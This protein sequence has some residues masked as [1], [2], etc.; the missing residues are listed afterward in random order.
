M[1]ILKKKPLISKFKKLRSSSQ[2]L[3]AAKFIKKSIQKA[4]KEIKIFT[5][6][7]NDKKIDWSDDRSK[8]WIDILGSLR[9]GSENISI[10]IFLKNRSNQDENTLRQLLAFDIQ[11]FEI[12]DEKF[13]LNSNDCLIVIDPFTEQRQCMK[14]SSSLTDQII[15]DHTYVYHSDDDKIIDQIRK[16]IEKISSYSKKI[17]HDD[18][19]SL[20][21]TDIDTVIPNNKKSLN[22]AI[23][24][25]N[26]F[27]SSTKKTIKIIDPYLQNDRFTT[28]ENLG[29]YLRYLTRLLKKGITIQI[30]STG[31]DKSNLISLKTFFKPL[32]YEIEI[33]SYDLTGFHKNRRIIHDRYVIVDDKQLV[34]LGKGL[35][36]FF[37][38]EMKGFLNNS[39]SNTYNSN[40]RNV[41]KVLKDSFDYYWDYEKC[42]D[43][44]I[45][46]WPKTD[47][48][49]LK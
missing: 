35:T 9:I 17:N 21:N 5:S 8:G 46:N 48:R 33:I 32:G 24:K 20:D 1:R 38:S 19:V 2:S 29:F 7:I 16:N 36:I 4:T 25:L 31:H 12:D 45:K 27:I 34:E 43:Q 11:V 14:I 49:I 39:I 10:S 30:L 47:T 37:E 6:T 41:R 40:I 23:S 13:D 22:E 28:E 3:D 18:L 44:K 15:K 42:P 26:N